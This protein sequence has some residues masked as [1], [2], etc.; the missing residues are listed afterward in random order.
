MEQAQKHD[1]RTL[2]CTDYPGGLDASDMIKRGFFVV[3][4]NGW[5]RIEYLSPKLVYDERLYYKWNGKT[6]RAVYLMSPTVFHHPGQTG[7]GEVCGY[8][9]GF[10]VEGRLGRPSNLEIVAVSAANFLETSSIENETFSDSGRAVT[11]SWKAQTIQGSAAQNSAAI[12]GFI[13]RLPQKSAA[14]VKVVSE[15]LDGTNSVTVFYPLADT[16]VDPQL[17]L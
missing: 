11:V 9:A 6:F 7:S 16:D 3:Q 17:K 12:S 4:R 14:L 1:E 5:Q 13:S 2:T 15:N 10:D 8:V